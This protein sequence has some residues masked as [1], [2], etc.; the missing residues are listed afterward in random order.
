MK[1]EDE[2]NL[3]HDVQDWGS[4][5]VSFLKRNGAEE[6]SVLPSQEPRAASLPKEIQLKKV[7]E[8]QEM[9]KVAMGIAEILGQQRVFRQK[10]S[11]NGRIASVSPVPDALAQL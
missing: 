4:Q 3:E 10:V 6:L 7:L 5:L 8:E 9:V 11:H 2:A 1:A